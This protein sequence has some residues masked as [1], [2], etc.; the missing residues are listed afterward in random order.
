MG[1]SL[2]VL[3]LVALLSDFKEHTRYLLVCF[4]CEGAFLQVNRGTN[5]LT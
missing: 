5:L 3:H 4:V 2:D 1:R